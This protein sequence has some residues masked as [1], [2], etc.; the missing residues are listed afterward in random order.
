MILCVAVDDHMGMMFNRRRQS[1]DR[2]LRSYL[3]E[4]VGDRRLWI[5]AYTKT[6]FEEPLPGNIIVDDHFLDRAAN[7]D[8]CFAE[9]VSLAD[10]GDRVK[11]VIFFKW[12]SVYPADQQFDLPMQQTE[13]KPGRVAEFEGY[14][15]KK[16]TVEEWQHECT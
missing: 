12:N 6:Q 11:K 5:N 13:W 7:E 2:R 8:F 9:D 15:H 1:Q 3:M 4:L 14:S 16:I 10:Y